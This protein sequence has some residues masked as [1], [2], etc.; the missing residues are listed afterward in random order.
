M[1]SGSRNPLIRTSRNSQPSSIVD[2]LEEAYE[3]AKDAQNIIRDEQRREQRALHDADTDEV[4]ARHDVH[5]HVHQ[6]SQPDV[7]I[8]TSVEVGP[9]KVK[10]LPKWAIAAIG[11][12]VAAGTALVSHF[13][14]K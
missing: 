14:S 4:T 13:A 10:G 6:H 1:S 9:V 8:E 12:L 3:A 11:L 5:V 7:E 2:P